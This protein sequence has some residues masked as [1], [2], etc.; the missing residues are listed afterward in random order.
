M[1]AV[2][3]AVAVTVAVATTVVGGRLGLGDAPASMAIGPLLTTV[4]AFASAHFQI[5]G[6][7][8]SVVQVAALAW[9]EPGKDIVVVHVVVAPPS[10]AGKGAG[11]ERAPVPL[12]VPDEDDVEPLPDEADPEHIPVVVG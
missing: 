2:V 7:S 8:A 9:H 6:Q 12:P 3:V 4:A 10:D 1:A 5:E 11:A